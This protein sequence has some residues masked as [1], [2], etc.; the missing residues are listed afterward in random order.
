MIRKDW[1]ALASDSSSELLSL[2]HYME[3]A[4][5]LIVINRNKE[6]LEN[7]HIYR[8][9]SDRIAFISSENLL[10]TLIMNE[11]CDDAVFTNH[12]YDGIINE[13][14][15]VKY[16]ISDIYKGITVPNGLDYKIHRLNLWYNLLVKEFTKNK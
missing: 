2:C 5:K 4:P 12:G 11:V 3:V 6:D 9:F 1:I 15:H 14:V 7:T 16:S 10:S 8:L 13:D